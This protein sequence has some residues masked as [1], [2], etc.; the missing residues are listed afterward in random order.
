MERSEGTRILEQLTEARP[1]TITLADDDISKIRKAIAALRARKKATQNYVDYYAGD[2]PLT[3]TSEKYRDYFGRMV[4]A[5]RENICPS[6]VDALADRLQITGITISRVEE[7]ELDETPIDAANPSPSNEDGDVQPAPVTP[8]RDPLADALWAIWEANRMN[9]RAGRVHKD[10]AKLGD[11]FVI[12]WK[13]PTT[14]EP[15]IY[16]QDSRHV[17][18]NYDPELEAIDW[19]AKAWIDDD[20]RG[21]ITLYDRA[22]IRRYRTPQPIKSPD[23]GLPGEKAQWEPMPEEPV[24]DT[25]LDR[26]PVFHFANDADVAEYGASELRDVIPIQDGLNKSVADLLISSE[27]NAYPQR[28]ATG[29]TTE[30]DPVTGKEREDF[31]PGMARLWKTA[32]EMAKF[33]E[34][35]AADLDKY[36]NMKNSFKA[37]AADVTGTPAHYMQM[38]PGSWPSGESLKTAEARFVAK[39]A[40][41]QG[42]FGNVWADVLETAAAIASLDIEGSI[43]MTWQDASPRSELDAATIAGLKTSVG[44]SQ[45]QVQRELGYTEEEIARMR[46]ETQAKAEMDSDLKIKQLNAVETDFGENA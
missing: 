20:K 39:V 12:V 22:Q 36:I 15:R 10:A 46:Q 28:W 35:A 24:V 29:L 31:Q 37:A 21:R 16:S 26:V 40:D 30:V 1:R 33:G 41:R 13:D 14:K 45:E 7:P 2:Q 9:V 34:F 27:F 44:V 18:V 11:A 8:S 42:A 23:Y 4:S 19:A 17:Y 6:V 3:Y 5:Y 25:G 43:K 38:T 32:D